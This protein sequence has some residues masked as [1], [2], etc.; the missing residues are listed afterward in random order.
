M[1]ADFEVGAVVRLIV[2]RVQKKRR[3]IKTRVTLTRS[4]K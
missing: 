2:Q 1:R 4:V 3:R